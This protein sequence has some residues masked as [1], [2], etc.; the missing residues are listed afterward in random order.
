MGELPKFLDFSGLL[1]YIL[2][3]MKLAQARNKS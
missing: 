1:E 3:K 2:I